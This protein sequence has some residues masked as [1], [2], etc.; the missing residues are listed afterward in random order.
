LLGRCVKERIARQSEDDTDS[1]YDKLP[2]LLAFPKEPLMKGIRLTPSIVSL[3][4]AFDLFSLAK[5]TFHLDVS[6]N[7]E[8]CERPNFN[9]P[10]GT[11][12]KGTIQPCRTTR[13]GC[14]WLADSLIESAFAFWKTLVEKLKLYTYGD[15]RRGYLVRVSR[16]KRRL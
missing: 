2:G 10:E 4:R 11:T 13:Y 3:I 16:G 8:V 1:Q 6:G 7:H 9:N 12:S 14:H 5:I 15:P